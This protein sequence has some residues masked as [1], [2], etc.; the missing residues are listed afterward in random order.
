MMLTA[1]FEARPKLCAGDALCAHERDDRIL[2][3]PPSIPRQKGTAEY[4]RV[5]VAIALIREDE[6]EPEILSLNDP[7]RRD[8]IEADAAHSIA[9]PHDE[10]GD[11][12]AGESA[13]DD[14]DLGRSHL[15]AEEC[16]E[17]REHSDELSLRRHG[18][19]HTR[20]RAYDS[21]EERSPEAIASSFRG[22]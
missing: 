16:R 4:D 21:A 12:N 11:E 7:L 9:E 10:R 8:H 18:Q 3:R 5:M 14:V 20:E 15:E 13:P 1:L 17:E 22:R 19:V 6:R 2:A